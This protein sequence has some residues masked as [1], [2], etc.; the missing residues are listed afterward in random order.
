MRNHNGCCID[1][2][3]ID[4]MGFGI[5]HKTKKTS[6]QPSLSVFACLVLLPMQERIRQLVL[7]SY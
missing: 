1:A 2:K 3:Q 4:V 5:E 7:I 6:R